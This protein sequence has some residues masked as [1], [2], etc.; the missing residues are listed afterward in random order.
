MTNIEGIKLNAGGDMTDPNASSGSS[1][2]DILNLGSQVYTNTLKSQ[3]DASNA[4]AAIQLEKLKIQQQQAV[5]AGT[6]TI[7]EKIKA[8]AMPLAIAGI[9]VI[10]GI[11]AYFYFKKKK[12]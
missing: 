2:T 1:W 4:Q 3:T 10:G 12:S 9:M 11:S 5:N 7:T 8:Y 6:S